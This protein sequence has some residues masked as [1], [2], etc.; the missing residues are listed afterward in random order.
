[1]KEDPVMNLEKIILSKLTDDQKKKIET[2]KSSEELLAIAKETGYELTSD[3]LEAVS[4]G[5]WKVCTQFDC[6]VEN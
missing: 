3:E 4:G 5:G 1:M 6:K 2:A